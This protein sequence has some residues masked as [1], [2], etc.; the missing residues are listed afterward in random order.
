MERR[1]ELRG[2]Y[3]VNVYDVDITSVMRTRALEFAKAIILTENQYSR[4]LPS[5][6]RDSGDVTLKQKIEVQRT[7]MGKLGELVFLTYLRVRGK[8]VSDTGMFEVYEGEENVDSYDFI[9]VHNQTVDVKT[10][11]RNNHRRLLINTEQFDNANKDYYVAVK[12]NAEDVDPKNKLVDWDNITKGT[13]LGY[14]EY[15]F[16]V[17]TARIQNFGEGPARFL[18][19]NRLLGIDRLI[20]EF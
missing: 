20:R 10:G 15:G 9:T 14:A 5:E 8:N 16:L 4:L 13:V 6:I 17:E 19:Y 11:F 18:E 7:Y 3:N 12:L 2:N 1:T